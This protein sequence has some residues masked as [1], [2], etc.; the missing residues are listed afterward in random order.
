M[1]GKRPLIGFL[2]ILGT[3]SPVG[4]NVAVAPSI[5]HATGAASILPHCRPSLKPRVL[6]SAFGPGIGY[7]PVWSV[8]IGGHPA[9]LRCGNLCV[10]TPH[11][12]DHKNLLVVAS[13]LRGQVT[14]QGGQIGGTGRLWFENEDPNHV[15]VKY[16]KILHLDPAWQRNPASK[17]TYIGFPGD[18]VF[19]RSGR[20]YLEAEYPGGNWCF[21]FTARH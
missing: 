8:G 5:A 13:R 1:Q 7:Y 16:V 9:S 2:L 6:S 10:R 14:L 12:W 4:H 17:Q 18:I 3:M 20:Y 19:P 11:G 15:L 21:T